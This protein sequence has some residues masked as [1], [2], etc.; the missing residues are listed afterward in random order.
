[1]LVSREPRLRQ[2][3]HLARERLRARQIWL[4]G[5]RARG[6][7][8]AESDWDILLILPNDASDQEL[9]ATVAWRVGHDAGLMADV[10]SDREEDVRAAVDVENTLA[11]VVA[12]E[13]IRLG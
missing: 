13:G 10:V 11:F 4:F 2:L 1:M 3:V 8:Y 5:S 6:D 9:D 7:A 12:R